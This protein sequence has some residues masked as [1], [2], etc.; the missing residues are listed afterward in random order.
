MLKQFEEEKT[1]KL[2]H[3]DQQQ[4]FIFKKFKET[5]DQLLK[6]IETFE[7]TDQSKLKS[8]SNQTKT[9][10]SDLLTLQQNIHRKKTARDKCGL[11]IAV[12]NASENSTK[13][14]SD[15][16]KVN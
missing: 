15:T 5:K 13:L 14:K 7:K 6:E 9:M 4:L 11:F 1:E 10:K 12:K 3:Y 8:L 2:K 16:E